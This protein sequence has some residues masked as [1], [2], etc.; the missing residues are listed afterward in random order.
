MAAR[1]V[2][3]KAAAADAAEDAPA[4][5]GR[6]SAITD[7]L[8]WFQ[9]YQIATS[10]AASSIIRPKQYFSA[11]N[12]LNVLTLVV[13]WTIT[14]FYDHLQVVDH[15]ARREVGHYNPCFG[16]DFPP[17]SYVAVCCAGLDVH[18]SLRYA[19]LESMRT[20]LLDTDGQTSWAERFSI[21]TA[22]LH[23]AAS[24]LWLLLWSVGPH[25]GRWVEH[26][27]IFTVC[28]L[29]RYLCTLGNYVE[30]AFG[31]ARQRARVTRKHTVHVVFYGLVTASLPLL[32][33]TD[34]V[35]YRSE[36]RS[37]MDPFLPWQVLQIMDAAW[38]LCL[39]TTTAFA[40]PEPPI[41]ITHRV[42]DSYNHAPSRGVDDYKVTEGDDNMT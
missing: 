1:R 22:W 18:L 9:L 30:S 32:Y 33:F 26:L 20:R 2:V 17:A 23:G 21:V 35:I 40:V 6:C 7:V 12:E 16:W 15:P 38:M 24:L 4:A 42:V 31:D 28:V 27:L 36:G 13:C 14:L 11:S 5:K 8:R 34:V 3:P 29:C 39:A 37:G 19:G 10:P 41:Q 25:D